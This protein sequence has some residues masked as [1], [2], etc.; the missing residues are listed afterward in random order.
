MYYLQWL[1]GRVSK[2][3]SSSH[4]PTVCLPATGMRLVSETGVWNCRVG[5]VDVP[6]TTYLFD[7]G[8]RD[9]YVFHAIVEDRPAKGGMRLSYRQVSSHERIDSV[10][11]GERN[12][13]QHV[14]G[15]AVRGPLAPSEAREVVSSTLES[16]M[17]IAP[18]SGRYKTA[19]ARP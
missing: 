14:V 3:L 1:P 12:L 6:F 10:R 2:F 15:I 5:D 7:E 9:V 13:G 19:L 8:G 17:N 4:Y 18:A 11:R 16:V